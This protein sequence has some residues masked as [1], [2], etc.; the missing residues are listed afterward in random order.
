MTQGRYLA[1]GVLPDLIAF[2]NANK[3]VILLTW[4]EPGTPTQPFLVIGPHLKSAGMPARVRYD[5]SS[6]LKV[7]PAHLR[8]DTAARARRRH[9]HQRPG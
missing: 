4:D 7:D 5:M 9:Q 2:A 3:G 1:Q 8:R 6:V